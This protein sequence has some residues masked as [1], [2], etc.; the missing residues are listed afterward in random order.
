M[1]NSCSRIN[2]LKKKKKKS[3]GFHYSNR[4]TTS[5]PFAKEVAALPKDPGDPGGA[6]VEH[7]VCCSFSS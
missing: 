6:G 5:V 7:E 3:C 4:K 1:K 2:A